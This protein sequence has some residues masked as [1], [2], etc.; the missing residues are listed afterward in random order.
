MGAASEGAGIR[1]AHLCITRPLRHVANLEEDLQRRK[2]LIL[3]AK[4]G[5]THLAHGPTHHRE[6]V[7]PVFGIT[8]GVPGAERVD[9]IE[10]RLH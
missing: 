4:D 10:E 6:E 3:L 2:H 7:I 8:G 5:K 9:V 1:D